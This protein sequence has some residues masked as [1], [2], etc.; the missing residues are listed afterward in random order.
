LLKKTGTNAPGQLAGFSV[1]MLQCAFSKFRKKIRIQG[2]ATW[3]RCLK[4]VENRQ[5]DFATGAYFS[6]E[7]AQNIRLFAAL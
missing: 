3:P 1:D 6:E 7:L 4:L 2:D 5:I